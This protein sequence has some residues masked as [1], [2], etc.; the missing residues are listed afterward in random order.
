MF[1]TVRDV[2]RVDDWVEYSCEDVREDGSCIDQDEFVRPCCLFQGERFNDRGYLF[3][4][5]INRNWSCIW[6]V[7]GVQEII[8]RL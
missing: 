7:R 4:S 3:A 8:V 1:K 5:N 6:V 2:T